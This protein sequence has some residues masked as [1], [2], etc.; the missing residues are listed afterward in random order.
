MGSERPCGPN[1]ETFKWKSHGMEAQPNES[2]AAIFA[3]WRVDEMLCSRGARGYLANIGKK[4]SLNR[5]EVAHNAN[6]LA[7]VIRHLGFSS[8]LFQSAVL[9]M[10]KSLLGGPI[11][12]AWIPHHPRLASFLISYNGSHRNVL[13]L[14]PLP[15][16]TFT[17]TWGPWS[18][19][20]VNEV[21][22]TNP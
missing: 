20:F 12:H 1:K 17:Y 15:G 5:H 7:P 9:F 11:E 6:A 8:H 13:T 3:E 14:C 21:V 19:Q 18:I 10:L 16:Q 4:A 2:V 22:S